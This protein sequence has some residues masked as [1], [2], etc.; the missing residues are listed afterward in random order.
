MHSYDIKYSTLIQFPN[1][2][3]WPIN[4]ILLDT[5]SLDES[6]TES[7][8][9]EGHFTL[10]RASKLESPHQMQFSVIPRTSLIEKGLPLWSGDTVNEF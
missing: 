10:S 3:I 6:E 9:N 1:K 8:G 2:S 7:N 5:T 4:G